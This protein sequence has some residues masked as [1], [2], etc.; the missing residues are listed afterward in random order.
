MNMH[1]KKRTK[2]DVFKNKWLDGALNLTSW[3]L[4]YYNDDGEGDSE[5]EPPTMA[6]VIPTALAAEYQLEAVATGKPP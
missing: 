3:I 2:T 5:L 4:V 6:L 1:W